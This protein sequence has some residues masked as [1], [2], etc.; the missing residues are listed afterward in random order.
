MK[1][2]HFH[3]LRN[4]AHG[5]I[6][7]KGFV[8]ATELAALLSAFWYESEHRKAEVDIIAVIESIDQMEGQ[9]S[10]GMFHRVEFAREDTEQFRRKDLFYYNP[11]GKGCFCGAKRKR[12]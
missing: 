8:S 6:M 10:N 3:I 2:E 9:P 1:G 12:K 11:D 4:H 7:E 5:L